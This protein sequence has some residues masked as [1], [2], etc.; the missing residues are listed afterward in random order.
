MSETYVFDSSSLSHAFE[1]LSHSVA[2]AYLEMREPREWYRL[3][4]RILKRFSSSSV[5]RRLLMFCD[6]FRCLIPHSVLNELQQ[7]P[8]YKYSLDVLLGGSEIEFKYVKA[9]GDIRGFSKAFKPRLI[10][11]RVRKDI[12]DFVSVKA[13]E[14]GFEGLSKQDLEGIALAIQERG[15]LV[16]SDRKQ[17]ELAKLLGINVVYT[18]GEEAKELERLLTY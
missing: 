1:E 12:L 3:K 7:D 4:P 2:S 6:M 11:L 9:R 14:Y 13:R 17:M 8:Y 16:T 10:P 18:I 5:T 15:T